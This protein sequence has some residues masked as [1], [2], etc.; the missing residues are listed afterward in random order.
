MTTTPKLSTSFSLKLDRVQNSFDQM[1]GTANVKIS[2]FCHSFHADYLVGIQK[3]VF[4]LLC[5]FIYISP[6]P[7]KASDC[8]YNYHVNKKEQKLKLLSGI[9]GL[10]KIQIHTLFT[11]NPVQSFCKSYWFFKMEKSYCKSSLKKQY[12]KNVIIF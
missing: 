6:Q 12:S 8:R 2:R 5:F 4:L 11:I 10:L 3:T 9:W 1:D 7:R